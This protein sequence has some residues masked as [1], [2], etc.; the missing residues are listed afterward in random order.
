M[1]VIEIQIGC[2]KVMQEL[3]SRCMQLRVRKCGEACILSVV[4]R[5]IGRCDT[6]LAMR[7]VGGDIAKH[8]LVAAVTALH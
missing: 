8:A 6:W 2:L 3:A 4:G 5:E 1:F 7:M